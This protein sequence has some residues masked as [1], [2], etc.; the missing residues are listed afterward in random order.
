MLQIKEEALACRE[1]AALFEM[2]Y[3]GKLYI[4]GPDA[5]AAADW[6][7]SANTNRPMG[8]TVYTCILNKLGRVEGDLTVSAVETGKGSPSDPIFRV[9]LWAGAVES[10]CEPLPCR[11]RH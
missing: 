9:R 5:Q 6:V 4:T 1:A 10:R 11:R 8:S 3:F 7:F 2:S